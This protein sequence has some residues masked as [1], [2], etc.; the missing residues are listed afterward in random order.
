MGI[1]SGDWEYLSDQILDRLGDSPVSGVRAV[2]PWGLQYEVVVM[3]DGLNGETHP[4]ITAWI[5]EGDTGNPR[6]I[7]L[8]VDV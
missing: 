7:T 3:I 4:V 8:Y 1:E 2:P 5:I 6:L